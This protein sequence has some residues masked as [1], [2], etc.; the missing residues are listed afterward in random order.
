MQDFPCQQLLS[1]RSQAK[2]AC[3]TCFRIQY[4]KMREDGTWPYLMGEQQRPKCVNCG[5]DELWS[6]FCQF[7]SHG[8]ACPKY[9]QE[10]LFETLTSR[11]CP[12]P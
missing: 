7:K 1:S 3:G 9:D 8:P 5:K 11:C 12:R 2:H 4:D 6:H 10:T